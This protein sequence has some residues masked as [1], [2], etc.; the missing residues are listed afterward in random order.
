MDNNG[1]YREGYY[2]KYHRPESQYLRDCVCKI[3]KQIKFLLAERDA[4]VKAYMGYETLYDA[5][6]RRHG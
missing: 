3:D 2:D 1:A 6:K 5:Q 4:M